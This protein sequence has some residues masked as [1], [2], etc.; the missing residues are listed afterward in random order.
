MSGETAALF[1]A[2]WS[3]AHC[4]WQ[5]QSPITQPPKHVWKPA[6]CGSPSHAD[7]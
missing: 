4:D 6:H 2:G 7:D 5:G 1:E 3:I